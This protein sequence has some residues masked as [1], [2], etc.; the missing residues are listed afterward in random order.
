VS[1]R[2]ALHQHRPPHWWT[3]IFLGLVLLSFS[4]G[5]VLGP[6]QHNQT[7]E[8]VE[9]VGA[10][11]VSSPVASDEA[12]YLHTVEIYRDWQIVRAHPLFVALGA[13][14]VGL[15]LALLRAVDHRLAYVV[16][17]V[18]FWTAS[19]LVRDR[20]AADR[21]GVSAESV[22]SWFPVPALPAALAT[23]ALWRLRYGE[24]GAAAAG[25]AVFGIVSQATWPSVG[26]LV[27]AVVGAPFAAIGAI[28]GS[29]L[30]LVLVQPTARGCALLVAGTVGASLVS[31]A[32]D[33]YLRR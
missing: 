11:P 20:S 3:R 23:T 26:P 19:V 14:W 28:V 17:L 10:I 18:S 31:G 6:F 33:L 21:L 5:P 7:A 16:A 27:G 9:T 30:G 8:K 22:A 32:V 25:G 24:L 1:A 15:S 29:Q 12:A 2:L 4:V 13:F